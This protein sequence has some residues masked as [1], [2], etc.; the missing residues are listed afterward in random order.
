M[1]QEQIKDFGATQESP[2]MVSAA[3]DKQNLQTCEAII[4]ND[5]VQRRCKLKPLKG[6]R[7][8]Y[9]HSDRLS[10]KMEKIEQ[11]MI[12]HKDDFF[13]NKDLRLKVHRILKGFRPRRLPD[14]E[15]LKKLGASRKEA[16]KQLNRSGR[17]NRD[18]HG[19][20]EKFQAWK[21]DAI[22]AIVA[23]AEQL[24]SDNL[25]V[26]TYAEIPKAD[27]Q[28]GI[29]VNASFNDRK[30]RMEVGARAWKIKSK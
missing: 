30:E 20:E 19:L 22:D 1:K 8:C 6:D 12:E 5:G 21:D 15:F 23:A 28:I 3:A 2:K 27:Y 29:R 11:L 14:K 18:M 25:T 7:F 9:S 16:K 24:C 10:S 13:T 4:T 17:R 26:E